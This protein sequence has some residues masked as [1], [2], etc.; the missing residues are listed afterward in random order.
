MYEATGT[1]H[2]L[3]TCL[4]VL[5]DLLTDVIALCSSQTTVR[6]DDK[7]QTSGRQRKEELAFCRSLPLSEVR[8]SQR[9]R[10]LRTSLVEQ[11]EPL[12]H[13]FDRRDGVLC[14]NRTTG[15][16]N[17]RPFQRAAQSQRRSKP[18][19]RTLSIQKQGEP[20]Q[21]AMQYERAKQASTCMAPSSSLLSNSEKTSRGNVIRPDVVILEHNNSQEDS[22][23]PRC[24]LPQM[25]QSYEMEGG[26]FSE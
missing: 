22:P 23:D 20:K 8:V 9:V 19:I 3:V 4:A 18:D 10:F 1:Q 5:F 17:E 15:I 2:L 14:N 6:G 24:F 12:R 21:L 26:W 25:M 13:S 16:A 7:E 11:H